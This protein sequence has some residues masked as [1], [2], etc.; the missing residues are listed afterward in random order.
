MECS[1]EKTWKIIDIDIVCSYHEKGLPYTAVLGDN[2][3]P[4]YHSRDKKRICIC[5]I[6]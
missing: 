4:Q 1:R 5:Y 6:L 2:S 3:Y